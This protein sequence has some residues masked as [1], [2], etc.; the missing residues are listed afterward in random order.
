MI[1]MVKKSTTNVKLVL[2]N[3]T[4]MF[5]GWRITAMSYFIHFSFV[6]NF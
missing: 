5:V 2:P 6:S 4:V 3:P 1:Y